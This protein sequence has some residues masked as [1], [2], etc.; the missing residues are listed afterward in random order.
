M[1]VCVCVVVVVVVV[2]VIVILHFTRALY[3]MSRVRKS[4]CV[5]LIISEDYLNSSVT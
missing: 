4:C 3:W 1:C 2:V 5:L